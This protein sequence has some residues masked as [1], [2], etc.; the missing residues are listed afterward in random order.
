M[1]GA[2]GVR[3]GGV[4]WYEGN[5]VEMPDM[6]EARRRLEP[7][8]IHDAIR[9]MRLCSLAAWLVAMGVLLIGTAW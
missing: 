4:N 7:R 3:L 2:L 9:L 1:A 5:A 6:G 8:C